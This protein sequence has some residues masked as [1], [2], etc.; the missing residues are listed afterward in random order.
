[1]SRST[2]FERYET[3]RHALANQSLSRKVS[4]STA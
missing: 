3:D 1:M 4:Q 2:G